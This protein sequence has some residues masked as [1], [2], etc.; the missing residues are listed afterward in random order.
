MCD[1]PRNAVSYPAFC[2]RSE[3][4]G[5]AVRYLALHVGDGTGGVRIHASQQGCARR[6]A[7]GVDHE[8]IAERAALAAR[9]DRGWASESACCRWMTTHPSG[10]L[11]PR[12]RRCSA[13]CSRRSAAREGFQRIESANRCTH[14]T[15]QV[16][17]HRSAGL[18]VPPQIALSS[19]YVR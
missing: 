16:L 17:Q 6:Q 1:F 12:C 13:S 8:S 7:Q 10:D 9:C 11:R 18:K 5:K 4:S 2:R 15:G 3:T 19:R 14:G